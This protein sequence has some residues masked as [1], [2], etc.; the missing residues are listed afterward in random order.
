MNEGNHFFRKKFKEKPI[1]IKLDPKNNILAHKKNFHLITQSLHRFFE[2]FHVIK[3]DFEKEIQNL[4]K[5]HSLFPKYG[6]ARIAL[7]IA[8]LYRSKQDYVKSL[9]WLEIMKN[10]SSSAIGVY[11]FLTSKIYI[12][13]NQSAKA[14]DALEKYFTQSIDQTI[15]T[16]IEFLYYKALIYFYGQNLKK[17]PDL[18][19]EAYKIQKNHMYYS[20]IPDGEEWKQINYWIS[21]FNKLSQHIQKKPI[22]YFLLPKEIGNYLIDPKLINSKVF[23]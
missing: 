13:T 18:Q 3:Y 5:Q 7:I 6:K 19:K 23:K 20:S 2:N 8:E 11:Y 1:S 4:E 22:D 14:H 10:D 12:V 15:S 9:E 21:R 17:I 16:K